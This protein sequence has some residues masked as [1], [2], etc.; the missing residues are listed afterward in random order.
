M[1]W[2]IAGVFVGAF[3]G[4]FFTALCSAG[5]GGDDENE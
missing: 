2:F 5:I 1:W 4:V 3:L